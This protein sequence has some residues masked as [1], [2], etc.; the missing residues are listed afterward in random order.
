MKEAVMYAL[1]LAYHN[2]YSVHGKI[3]IDEDKRFRTMER[4]AYMYSGM[5]MC[6]L[7]ERSDAILFFREACAVYC[8]FWQK[9]CKQLCNVLLCSVHGDHLMQKGI[10]TT[11][12][13][14]EN[15]DTCTCGQTHSIAAH[16]IFIYSYYL[17]LV[18]HDQERMTRRVS[19]S[20]YIGNKKETRQLPFVSV[21]YAFCKP[22]KCGGQISE[23]PLWF[24]KAIDYNAFEVV[25]K[26]DPFGM[27]THQFATINMLMMHVDNVRGTD[28]VQFLETC[29]EF[30]I[31]DMLADTQAIQLFK[32]CRFVA[33]QVPELEN[34]M[35]LG[36]TTDPRINMS[37]VS[38]Y[39]SCI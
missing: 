27:I 12:E 30:D 20:H 16:K 38:G 11:E 22:F 24:L 10:A 14:K 8:Y 29:S 13:G 36:S 6:I 18:L 3:N 21:V 32:W 7:N 37:V 23:V 28:T 15:S 2:A 31:T 9:N 26:D 25:R 1:W 33:R 5:I 4:L 17:V 39:K 35:C 19:Y 34:K